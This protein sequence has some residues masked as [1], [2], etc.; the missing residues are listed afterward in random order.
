M[1]AQDVSQTSRIKRG[2]LAQADQN[3]LYIDEVNLLNRE[4]IDSILGCCCPRFVHSPRGPVSA[5]F[6][7]R[8][9]LIGSM[10]PEE[11]ILKAPDHGS[12]RSEGAGAWLG[13]PVERLEVYRRVFPT[14]R[15][16]HTIISQFQR[17][18]ALASREIQTAR[19]MLPKVHHLRCYSQG[20]HSVGSTARYRFSYGQRSTLFEASRAYA[21]AD[22]SLEVK[23]DDLLR[24]APMALRLRKSDFI[25]KY[26]EHQK[27]EEEMITRKIA[28]MKARKK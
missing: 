17:D 1:N 24:I 6:R 27:V 16:P 9:T 19:D 21:A 28:P 25:A 18:T 4:I 5:T 20:R 10:N 14:R 22:G 8:F 26:F 3:I 7:S 23:K 11:G 13:Q 12:I 2:L 15:N